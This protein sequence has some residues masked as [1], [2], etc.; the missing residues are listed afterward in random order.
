[1]ALGANALA[2]WVPY[3]LY[4]FAGTRWPGQADPTL[5][6]LMYFIA[7]AALLAVALGW[8]S[9]FNWTALMLLGWNLFRSRQQLRE[10]V[11]RATRLDHR[12]RTP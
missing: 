7:L 3:Y 2:R 4:R 8:S 1:M 6:R 5:I 12:A 10:V 9:L 11:A